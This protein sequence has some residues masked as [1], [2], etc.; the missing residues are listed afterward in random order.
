MSGVGLVIA[1]AVIYIFL[2]QVCWSWQCATFLNDGDKLY[3]V[4]PNISATSTDEYLT[5]PLALALSEVDG[6]VGVAGFTDARPQMFYTAQKSCTALCSE[7]LPN[8]LGALGLKMV[9]GGC[10]F[11]PQG[12]EMNGVV[13]PASI[14][15]KLFGRE[16]VVGEKVNFKEWDT[17]GAQVI[18]GVYEDLPDG[19]WLQNAV[20]RAWEKR[21]ANSHTTW[22]YRTYVRVEDEEHLGDIMR[23]F[24]IR[25]RKMC[26]EDNMAS[27]QYNN[28]PATFRPMTKGLL[29]D[30]SLEHSG[31]VMTIVLLLSTLFIAVIAGISTF[32]ISM[33]DAPSRMKNVNTLL[34]MGVEKRELRMNIIGSSLRWSMGAFLVAAFVTIVGSRLGW[35]DSLI[36]VPITLTYGS[37]AW[38]M[39][40]T[41]CVALVI[42]VVSAVYP[43]VY[44]TSFPLSMMIKGRF[45]ISPR[46]R[47]LRNAILCIQ[48]AMSF[49]IVLFSCV[50]AWQNYYILNY[51]YGFDNKNLVF[52][53]TYFVNDA[54]T[55]TLGDVRRELMKVKGVDGV[56]FT[57]Y[58]PGNVVKSE[59]RRRA[60]NVADEAFA[61]VMKFGEKTDTDNVYG[62]WMLTKGVRIAPVNTKFTNVDIPYLI[63]GNDDSA[64]SLLCAQYIV[65]H[66]EKNADK[67]R[68][69][70]D[71]RSASMRFNAKYAHQYQKDVV[72]NWF[73]FKSYDDYF[74]A[75]YTREVRFAWQMLVFAF[76]CTIISML[77]IAA[78][79][80]MENRYM[81][82]STAIRRVLGTT[83]EEL[84]M[85]QLEKY[86]LRLMIGALVGLPPAY[87]LAYRWLGTF[88]DSSGIPLMLIQ[89]VF[90]TVCIIILLPIAVQ[91]LITTKNNLTLA[92]KAE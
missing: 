11:V 25:I 27:M 69:M 36:I 61:D 29:S 71:L 68:V 55:L 33:T 40:I 81:Q 43:A 66:L 89:V 13:M 65:A 75:L 8:G 17:N 91:N 70:A 84:L 34:V 64:V 56:A 20:Y 85:Q 41:A 39:L 28:M 60:M 46:G 92:I 67:D 10:D 4:S 83:T 76:A 38:M 44:S 88:G 74:G 50:V 21:F 51:D 47:K 59:W 45:A 80:M 52:A 12:E 31:N 42:G 7:V 79:T 5:G 87:W 23:D 37:N 19:A 57:N 18:V 90:V 26:D 77:G 35:F 73:A 58:V 22:S 86:G 54:D 3:N 24:L 32:N 6:V 16:N 53:K 2:T 48:F 78:I 9:D 63:N 14:A 15:M 72:D 1:Y 82:R 30:G 49:A 62:H